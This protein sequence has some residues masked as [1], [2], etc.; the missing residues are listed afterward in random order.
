MTRSMNAMVQVV[1]E[2]STR[3]KRLAEL[4]EE[5]HLCLGIPYASHR[6]PLPPLIPLTPADIEPPAV[7]S[8]MPPPPLQAMEAPTPAPVNP[9]GQE[10][11][12][13][14]L[15]DAA[16]DSACFMPATPHP[17]QKATHVERDDGLAPLPLPRPL[18]TFNTPHVIG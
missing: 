10:F 16:E 11:P 7:L 18:A 3:H 14:P 12:T 6:G 4:M 15:M 9:Q 1:G 8:N 2:D 17:P 5:T 13:S